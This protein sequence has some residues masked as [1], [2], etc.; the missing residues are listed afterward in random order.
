MKEVYSEK[1]AGTFEIDET[2]IGGKHRYRKG[3]NKRGFNGQ[4]NKTTVIGILQRGGRVASQSVNKKRSGKIL[5]PIIENHVATGSTI[6]TDDYAPYK[7]LSRLGYNHKVI[8]HNRY[9]FAY[10]EIHTNSIEGYWAHV[11]SSIRGT[12]KHVS[13]EHLQKYLNEFDFHRNRQAQTAMQ[14]FD[15]IIKRLINPYRGT[16]PL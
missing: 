9:R 5:L 2:F 7:K 11:K 15:E 12:N 16:A 6:N 4:G 3:K 13:K 10:G 1:L 14:M 8:H